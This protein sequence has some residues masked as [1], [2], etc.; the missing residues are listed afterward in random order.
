[1]MDNEKLEQLKIKL[2]K[3]AAQ[4]CPSDDPEFNAY[5]YSGGNYDDAYALGYDAGEI[6]CASC[7]LGVLNGEIEIEKL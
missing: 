3:I 7:I 1:M 4:K 6:H 2:Q 5:D